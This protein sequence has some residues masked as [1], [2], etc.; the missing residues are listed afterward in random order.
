MP[1]SVTLR[2]MASIYLLRGDEI[3]LLYRQGSKVVNNVWIGSAGGHME[4]AEIADP[5]SC[6]LRELQE[7]LGLSK[8]DITPPELRYITLRMTSGEIRQNYYYFARLQTDRALASNEGTL[9][10]FRVDELDGL[11][12]AYTARYM[13]DH[14]LAE[15][16]FTDVVYSGTANGEKVVFTELNAF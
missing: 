4:P 15:G 12:M 8:D 9:R 6:A 3:L 5:E 14:W 10:W 13:I 1:S 7:E 11:P 2:S 16:R